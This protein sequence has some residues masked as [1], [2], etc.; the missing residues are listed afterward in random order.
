MIGVLGAVVIGVAWWLQDSMSWPWTV[1]VG[2]ATAAGAY[3]FAAPGFVRAISGPIGMLVFMVIATAVI[4]TEVLLIGS[5]DEVSAVVAIWLLVGG[6]LV[7][8]F[9]RRWLFWIP[10]E[11]M[12]TGAIIAETVGALLITTMAAG[13]VTATLASNDIVTT[14]E[15]LGGEPIWQFQAYYTWHLV[16]SVPGLQLPTTFDVDAPLDATGVPAGILLFTYRILVILPIVGAITQLVQQRR[17]RPEPTL[18]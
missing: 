8:N 17:D 18:A 15:Q 12:S 16:D 13:V 1:G 7:T 10:R 14:K 2:V 3:A 4:Q 9:W 5:D 11:H 6:L